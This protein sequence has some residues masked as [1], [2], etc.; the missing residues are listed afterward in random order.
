MDDNLIIYDQYVYDAL[1]KC[2]QRCNSMEIVMDSYVKTLT[3]M[4]TN[5]I[6][7]G[8]V[9]D[10]LSAFIDAAKAL[11]GE[12]SQLGSRIKDLR[13]NFLSEID[14]ADSYLF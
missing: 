5:A 4:H 9:A 10:A 12:F 2:Y 11:D 1:A 3:N 14:E 8:D 6:V 13:S 7:S